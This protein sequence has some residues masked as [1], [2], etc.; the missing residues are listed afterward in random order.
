M[1][2]FHQV[3]TTVSSMNIIKAKYKNTIILKC[4]SCILKKEML[5]RP[6]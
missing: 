5:Y 3:K 1:S 4:Q 6:T 2:L